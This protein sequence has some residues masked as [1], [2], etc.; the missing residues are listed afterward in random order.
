MTRADMAEHLAGVARA[1]FTPE[2]YTDL[3]EPGHTD[4]VERYLQAASWE[5][6]HISLLLERAA[7]AAGGWSY[8]PG[9]LW[10]AT[11]RLQRAITAASEA[12]Q[13]K[14]VGRSAREFT[15]VAL[16]W[17]ALRDRQKE[18]DG[19]RQDVQLAATR[20]GEEAAE[21]QLTALAAAGERPKGVEWREEAARNFN[22]TDRAARRVWDAVAKDYPQLSSSQGKP[23]ARR[24]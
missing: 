18:I 14:D 21:A 15:A 11:C 20:Q 6:A 12:L 22:L 5:C 3:A 2:A 24:A 4:G 8:G 9:S 1:T 10:D 7:E 23:K 16:L 19:L 17:R 13:A